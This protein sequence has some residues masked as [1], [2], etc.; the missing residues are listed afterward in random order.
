M[1]DTFELWIVDDADAGRYMQLTYS[2]DHG[3]FAGEF[4]PQELEDLKWAI[5]VWETQYYD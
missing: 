3:K 4:S 5:R 2:G 1:T